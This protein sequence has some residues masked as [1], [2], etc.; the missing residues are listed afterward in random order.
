M[1]ARSCE[2]ESHPAHTCIMEKNR[3]RFFSFLCVFLHLPAEITGQLKPRVEIEACPPP[4]F[5]DIFAC[6]GEVMST[7]EAT[8]L[9][10]LSEKFA[11]IKYFLYLCN[12]KQVKIARNGK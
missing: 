6:R 5:A 10:F 7:R 12:V 3:K 9:L 8:P 4:I 11:Y 2:F 1:V